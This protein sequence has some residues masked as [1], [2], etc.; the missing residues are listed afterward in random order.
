MSA[1]SSKKIEP[2]QCS[3]TEAR[4][5]V[6]RLLT[7]GMALLIVVLLLFGRGQE[8]LVNPNK[9]TRQQLMAIP[10]LGPEIADRILKLRPFTDASDLVRRVN[11]ISNSKLEQIMKVFDLDDDG[12]GDCCVP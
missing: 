1:A 4:G 6:L 11:G 3:V 7:V 8:R 10:E 5:P 9:A 2:H 12:A